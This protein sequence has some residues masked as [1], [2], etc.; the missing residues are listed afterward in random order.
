MPFRSVVVELLQPLHEPWS[1]IVT[2]PASVTST[3][4]RSPPSDWTMGR[5]CWMTFSTS[6]RI[7][8]LLRLGVTAP[9]QRN[10]IEYAPCIET[11]KPSGRFVRGIWRRP[12]ACPARGRTTFARS[13]LCRPRGE[14]TRRG[15]TILAPEYRRAVLRG[16]PPVLRVTST[17]HIGGSP[18]AA[19]ALGSVEARLQ[20]A[21]RRLVHRRRVH[22]LHEHHEVVEVLV[23]GRAGRRLVPAQ[24]PRARVRAGALERDRTREAAGIAPVL[25]EHRAQLRR[26][27]EAEVRLVD[28]AERRRAQEVPERVEAV[29]GHERAGLERRGAEAFRADRAAHE[30][31][32]RR[33]DGRC[34]VEAELLDRSVRRALE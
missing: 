4:S 21:P 11:S 32:Q 9:L 26:E 14:R 27:V 19:A 25:R 20:L 7:P 18:R 24:P 28:A 13:A 15:R 8:Y 6:T 17:A 29:H 16:A 2:T 22:R 34:V 5:S 23:A 12:D 30:E 10:T 31:E 1:R 3:S 33:D